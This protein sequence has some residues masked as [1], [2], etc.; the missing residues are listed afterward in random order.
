MAGVPTYLDTLRPPGTTPR[1][2]HTPPTLSLKGHT[3]T[4]A[5]Q[6][7]PVSQCL[8]IHLKIAMAELCYYYL[9]I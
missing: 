3:N 7:A 8:V 2:P 1:P 9:R 6:F 4:P 5:S